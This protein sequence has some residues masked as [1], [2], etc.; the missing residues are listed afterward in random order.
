MKKRIN[1]ISAISGIVAV[2]AVLF[3]GCATMPKEADLKEA[4][5]TAADRYWK[6]RLDE[7]AED[8]Y[9]MEV[10]Q[11]LPPFE[12][13][14]QLATAMKKLDITSISVKAVSVKGD[15]GD[16]DLEWS[17]MLP[18]VP[19]PFHQIIKDRWIYKD[20]RWQHLSYPG[21]RE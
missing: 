11:G 20:G 10:E 13:Y 1:S 3:L 15:K 14:R 19:K 5:K 2:F 6:L 18:K 7:K 17:Y 21:A 4:L 8:T 12:K 9:K 16:V